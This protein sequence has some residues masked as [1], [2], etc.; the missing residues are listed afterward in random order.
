MPEQQP[1]GSWRVVLND[2][3]V[4]STL[5]LYPQINYGGIS[6]NT[7]EHQPVTLRNLSNLWQYDSV[8]VK[9]SRWLSHTS[10]TQTDNNYDY[11]KYR[12]SYSAVDVP[13]ISNDYP[14]SSALISGVGL[15]SNDVVVMVNLKPIGGSTKTVLR[16][17]QSWPTQISTASVYRNNTS[18]EGVLI[19]FDKTQTVRTIDLTMGTLNSDGSASWI[20]DTTITAAWDH[21]LLQ[22][23]LS[24]G[25]D[26]PADWNLLN[27]QPTNQAGEFVV[28][29]AFTP[30]NVV[31]VY[32]ITDA[33][34]LNTLG[35]DETYTTFNKVALYSQQ[36]ATVTLTLSGSAKFRSNN[37][38]SCTIQL[39][40]MT[41]TTVEFSDKQQETV[42]VT[43]SGEGIDTQQAS[44]NFGPFDF[45]NSDMRMVANSGAPAAT[46]VANSV[47]FDTTQI[48]P[49]AVTIELSGSAVFTD[50]QQNKAV[51]SLS[52][53]F[54]CTFNIINTAA[55][56]VTIT[57]TID[58]NH[59]ITTT[60]SFVIA[61]I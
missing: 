52:G 59:V 37:M 17:Q 38:S 49:S 58:S 12:D 36:N 60:S 30:R 34:N 24:L 56:T 35:G 21:S 5:E 48:R 27:I 26:A 7:A 33:P 32:P 9:G 15:S 53:P 44:V 10:F 14:L 43:L 54:D 23:I 50:S 18:L 2:Q 61:D 6:S 3:P 45:N 8:R 4:V 25:A 40:A 20:A 22:P 39:T 28:D 16:A 1:D 57:A 42:A 29:L 55:E 51:Y 46:G 11:R 19:M 13:D 41:M 47:Y 31:T